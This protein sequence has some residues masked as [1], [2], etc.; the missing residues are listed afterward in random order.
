MLFVEV[1]L[2]GGHQVL[3][4]FLHMCFGLTDTTYRIIAFTSVDVEDVSRF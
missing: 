1:V 3:K 2:K 4:I